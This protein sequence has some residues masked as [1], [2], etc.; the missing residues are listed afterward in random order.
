MVF[1]SALIGLVLALL[2]VTGLFI[3]PGREGSDSGLPPGLFPLFPSQIDEKSSRFRLPS[4]PFVK[5]ERTPLRKELVAGSSTRFVISVKNVSE[6]A[7][8]NLT[9]EER[10]DETLLSVKNIDS[11]G[12]LGKNII[13]WKIPEIEPGGRFS[14]TYSFQVL[15]DT[16]PQTIETTAFVRG[17]AI[18][19]SLSSSRMVTSVLTIISLPK[20]GVDLQ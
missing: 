11:E 7:L 6:F 9:L 17:E 14:A 18:E 16:I 3:F 2:I 8:E 20:T 1:R 10:F 19:E 13:V 4:E 5:I 12:T 15:P